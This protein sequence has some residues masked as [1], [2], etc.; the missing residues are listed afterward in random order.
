MFNVSPSCGS[1][2]D[3]MFHVSPRCGSVQDDR[4]H[5]DLAKLEQH[6]SETVEY[7]FSKS[8]L[9]GVRPAQL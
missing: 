6:W 2:Q 3:D 9:R 4:F 7:S 8:C 1:V 5:Q